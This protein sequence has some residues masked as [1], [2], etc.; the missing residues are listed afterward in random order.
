MATIIFDLDGTLIDTTEL[1]LPTYREVIRHFENVPIP[2]EPTMLQTF[3][4]PDQTIWELLMP[5]TTA[6]QQAQAHSLTD[7]IIHERMQQSDVLLP[8]AVEV[9]EA[10]KDAGH[11]LTVAS[12]CGDTYL[13]AT[14][15]SQGIRP[16]F[17]HPLCLGTVKGQRKADILSVHFQRFAKSD[18]VMVG[19]RHSDIEAAQYHQ[20]P[21]IGCAFGFGNVDELNGSAAIIMSLPELL[22]LFA[23]DGLSLLFPHGRR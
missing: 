23:D 15:D 6:D 4:M 18:A 17:T 5:G 9:L 11:T 16:F 21:A 13:D 12:N 1:V 8:H 14:L 19:D 7:D 3:G 20:I 22:P 10:L 2:S